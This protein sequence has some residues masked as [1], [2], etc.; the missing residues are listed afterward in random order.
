MWIID[1]YLNE[2]RSP[3][4]SIQE[5]AYRSQNY[6]REFGERFNFNQRL[7]GFFVPPVTSLYTFSI[8]SDDLS[9]FY[10]SRSMNESEKELVA[11]ANAH[12]SGDWDKFPT[13]T[14][15]PMK[16]E[17]GQYYYI[18]GYSNNGGG[19]SLSMIT[20]FCVV[21]CPVIFFGRSL[22]FWCKC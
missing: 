14:S 1:D 6:A 4:T 16:M 8:V 20:W 18:E 11:F 3:L 5:K 15:S 17:Q 21:K 19:V 2:P 13:Q 7:S 9:R 10:V 22:E 12:T